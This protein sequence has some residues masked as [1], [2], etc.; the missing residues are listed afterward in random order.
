MNGTKYFFVDGVLCGTTIRLGPLNI[1]GLGGGVYHNMNR[2]ASGAGLP[3]CTIVPIPTAIG[4]SVSGI[5]YTPNPDKGLGLKLTVAFALPRQEAFNA[6]ATFEILF[7]SPEAGGGLSDAWLYGNARFMEAMDISAVPVFNS[8]GPPNLTAMVKANL[9]LHMDFN[10]KYFFGQLDVYMNV[11]GVIKG[12]GPND[13]LGHAEVSFKPGEWYIKVGRPYYG[14]GPDERVGMV[15]NVPVIGTLA[16]FHAYLQIGQNL[17]PMPPLPAH[18]AALTGAS[19]SGNFSGQL[20]STGEVSNLNKRSSL[21]SDGDGFLFGSDIHIGKHNFEFLIFRATLAAQLGFDMS[22]LTYGENAVCEN[23]NN[24]PL[25]INGWYASGQA[26]AGLDVGIGIKVKVFGKV[27]TFDIFDMSAAVALQASLPNP[28]WM[29]GAV[30]ANYNLLN[31][32][33]KGHCDF[34]FTIGEPCQLAGATNPYGDLSIIS[35][36][37]PSDGQDMVSPTTKPQVHFNFP[38]EEPFSVPDLNNGGNYQYHIRMDE[39][40][41]SWHSWKLPVELEWFNNQKSLRIVPRVYLPNNDTLNLFI[42]VHVDSN[43]VNIH[44]EERSIQFVTMNFPDFIFPQ[45][46]AGSYPIAGQYNFYKEELTNHKG[47][48]LLERGQPGLFR[49]SDTWQHKVRFRDAGGSCTT[50]PVDYDALDF[51]VTFDIPTGFLQHEEVYKM[52]LIRVPYASNGYAVDGCSNLP[53]SQPSTGTQSAA[54]AATPVVYSDGPPAA[55]SSYGNNSQQASPPSVSVLYGMTFRVSEYNTFLEKISAWSNNKTHTGSFVYQTNAGFEPFDRFEL[56]QGTG[57]PPLIE[58]QAL[59]AITGWYNSEDVKKLHALD[60]CSAWGCISNRDINVY[61]FPPDK[62]VYFLSS[63]VPELVSSSAFSSGFLPSGSSNQQQKL[64]YRAAEIT[65]LDYWYLKQNIAIN[66]SLNH[67]AQ[68]QEVI[69][70]VTGLGNGYS[71]CSF[72]QLF[73]GVP[74]LIDIIPS[75]YIKFNCIE[76]LPPATGNFPVLFRYRPP[77][78]NYNT[79]EKTINLYKN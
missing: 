55:S 42:K 33:V 10:Q 43:N 15:V 41:I 77:G 59:T 36:I 63:D 44:T 23:F 35:M 20:G 40:S 25:G 73:G 21:I 76:N 7:N 9:D 51:K 13:R 4:S 61:G 31:G 72:Y 24:A 3:L 67:G 8:T 66:I 12:S 60:P 27:K 2:P 50:V 17:D 48:I 30:G 56:G 26:W 5:L 19:Q 38:I 1:H 34:Q 74:A 37:T 71:L 75:A 57:M 58:M 39:A 32:L 65:S 29:E 47:Y 45:N 69:N 14:S 62:A 22:M 68:I 79:S 78:L 53:L 52:E 6:N 28:F 46:V 11:G 18:I 16:D 70:D 49:D 64:K 54:A